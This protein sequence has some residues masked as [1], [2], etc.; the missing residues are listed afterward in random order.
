MTPPLLLGT[1][2]IFWGW[3]SQLLLYAIPMALI[4][5]VS[6]WVKWRL[7]LTDSDFNRLADISAALWIIVAIYLFSQQSIHGLFTLLNWLPLLFFLMISAQV[8]SSHGT[9]KLSSIVVSLRYSEGKKGIPDSPRFDLSY[10]YLYLC[11]LAASTHHSPLFFIGATLLIAWGLWS[12]RPRRYTVTTWS[13][14]LTVAMVLGFVMQGGLFR[15]Q[16]ELEDFVVSWLQERFWLRDPFRQDTAIGDIGQLK[17]SG[18]IIL[19]VASTQPGLLLR[20]A[21]YNR[22]YRGTWRTQSSQFA[23]V[24]PDKAGQ[25]WSWSPGQNRASPLQLRVST[26]LDRGQG[27]LALPTGTFAL[28]EMPMVSVFR[29]GLGAVKVTDGP[30]FLEYTTLFEER[31]TLDDLP[32]ESDTYIPTDE[33]EAVLEIA[34]ALNLSQQSPQQ[35]VNT[36]TQFFRQHFQY[37]LTLTGSRTPSAI[38]EFLRSQRQGHCEYFATATVL[39]LRA[40]G[41]PARYASGYAVAEFSELEGVYVV[42]QRHAHAWAMAFIDAQWQ[43]VD[44]TPASWFEVEAEMDG[45]WRPVADVGSWLMVVWSRWRWQE[46]HTSNTWLLWLLLPLGGLLAWR[47]YTHEKVRRPPTAV[48]TET[49][50]KPAFHRII[51]HFTAGGYP[52]APGETLA[53]WVSRL[54]LSEVARYELMTIVAL[55]RRYRFDPAAIGQEDFMLLNQIVEKWLQQSVTIGLPNSTKL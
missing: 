22:Y 12:V 21:S 14:L 37:S 29:H 43:D 15:L 34:A 33:Q 17:Q 5:E 3:Q 31:A 55:H 19:R 26:Y 20:E 53:V 18:R 39:L 13:I 10:P 54:P 27:M 52:R 49:T 2:L 48:I 11:L 38:A 45:G 40:A 28:T 42:R 50:V 30:D 4:L 44:T 24:T 6:R 36:V 16:T 9:I 32:S 23:P 7:A 51:E 25:Q 46:S 35:V 1:T 8:Y 41:I 47:V